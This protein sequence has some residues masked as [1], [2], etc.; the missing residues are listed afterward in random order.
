MRKQIKRLSAVIS[1]WTLKIP[2]KSLTAFIIVCSTAVLLWFAD[3]LIFGSIS[4]QFKL[5]HMSADEYLADFFN[6][7]GYC[8]YNDPYNCTAYSG[9]QEKGYPPMS[10]LLLRP[11][12]KL[13]DMDSYYKNNY[14]LSMRNEPKIALMYIIIVVLFLL[15]MYELIRSNI[16]GSANE[17]RLFAFLVVFSSPVIFTIERGNILLLSALASTVFVFYYN[18]SNPVKKEAALLSLAFA[19]SLKIAPAI[20][21]M[22]LITNKQYKEAV[23][24]A[25][26]GILMFLL[27]F[28]FIKGGFTNIPLFIRNI[29]YLSNWYFGTGDC[30]LQAAVGSVFPFLSFWFSGPLRIVVGAYLVICSMFVKRRWEQAA[31]LCLALLFIP[32][33]SAY[34]N[35]L[36][37]IP[38]LVL[39]FNEEERSDSD[40]A[41]LVAFILIF[42]LRKWIIGIFS[43]R[44][45]L[46]ILTLLL[47]GRGTSTF[48]KAVIEQLAKRGNP[49]LLEGKIYKILIGEKKIITKKQRKEL[50]KKAKIIRLSVLFFLLAIVSQAAIVVENS[51]D[52]QKMFAY[53]YAVIDYKIGDVTDAEAI[54]DELD[55]YKDSKEMAEKCRGTQ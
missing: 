16:K 35:L 32:T 11:F 44:I 10:Y 49:E 47:L 21:G 5:F 23:R 53:Y 27:P 17:K 54:F 30:T 55:D 31:M 3:I 40:L 15:V 45:A 2:K 22:L 48:L 7:V 52:L 37:F 25:L 28:A 4:T 18:S 51:P 42:A 33:F 26:Y 43:N 19:F 38:V 20:L 13:V 8:G 1:D 41:A 14:F 29:R 34:Y 39:F 24:S 9:L 50:S 46:L 36:Y 12:S 6:V